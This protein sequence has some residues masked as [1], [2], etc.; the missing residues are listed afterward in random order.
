MVLFPTVRFLIARSCRETTADRTAAHQRS[1]RSR[2]DLCADGLRKR[3][4]RRKAFRSARDEMLMA[5][6]ELELALLKATANETVS[7]ERQA[8]VGQRLT[9]QGPID[10]R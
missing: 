10:S 8:A 6:L 2:D 5:F 9:D 4:S 3:A 1:Q 7:T